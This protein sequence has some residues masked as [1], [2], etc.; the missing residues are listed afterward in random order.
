MTCS[1][2]YFVLL[3]DILPSWEMWKDLFHHFAVS[4][5]VTGS[6]AICCGTGLFAPR[7]DRSLLM[8]KNT[9]LVLKLVEAECHWYDYLGY[10]WELHLSHFPRMQ[11]GTS[12]EQQFTF[13]NYGAQ[14]WQNGENAAATKQGNYRQKA[15]IEQSQG[16]PLVFSLKFY[17]STGH[18]RS[19]GCKGW[20][21]HLMYF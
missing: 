19:A 11:P 1:E 14:E 17:L 10:W 18:S 2:E 4:E 7:A 12:P 8:P 3:M 9:S 20:M 6:V 21:Q 5:R 15:P 13:S 16:E